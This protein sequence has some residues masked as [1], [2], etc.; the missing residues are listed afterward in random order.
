MSNGFGAWFHDRPALGVAAAVLGP[1]V[2]VFGS[3]ALFKVLKP[4]RRAR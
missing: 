2:L 3:A 4:A 1:V